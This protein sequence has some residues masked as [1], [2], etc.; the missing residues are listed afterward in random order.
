MSSVR[1]TERAKSL[2][3]TPLRIISADSDSKPKGGRA[4]P[5]VAPHYYSFV[6]IIIYYSFFIPYS[7]F[8]LPS[9]LF[10]L[11]FLPVFLFPASS[12]FPLSLPHLYLLRDGRPQ[13]PGRIGWTRSLPWK[14]GRWLS[15]PRR[16]GSGCKPLKNQRFLKFQPVFLL[17]G[18][19]VRP[20]AIPCGPLT[21]VSATQA[22][23]A[24]MVA[25]STE[26]D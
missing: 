14:K 5:P 20:G 8:I 18:E 17:P 9:S 4:L 10:P 12:S 24:G 15:L 25:L 26:T 23:P 11:P 16:S 6:V 19:R 1:Q 2:P 22:A 7:F 13:N 21:R 3:V